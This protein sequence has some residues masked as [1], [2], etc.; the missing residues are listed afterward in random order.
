M[1]RRVAPRR[2]LA[3]LIPIVVENTSRGERAFDIFS[4]LLK[5]RI[6]MLNGPV[7]DDVAATITAQLLFL[8][9]EDPSAP[10]YMYL[11]SPGGA[12]TAGLA[13]YDTMRYVRA[14]VSTLCLGQAASMGSLLLAA[15]DR[16]MRR[17]L[18]NAKLAIHAEEILRT[19][20]RLNDLYVNHTNQDLAD[21]ERV[22]ERDTFFSPE[23]ARDF[24]VIDEVVSPRKE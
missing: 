17:A 23:E 5:E 21:I 1:L 7:T 18:P 16:G 19:R 15:G 24:G 2:G 10:I 14:P 6:V 9:A 4:R 11:N 8:E 20:R 13:I 12:V 3:A 22:M